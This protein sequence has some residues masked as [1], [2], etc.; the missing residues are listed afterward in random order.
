MAKV[1]PDPD[2]KAPRPDIRVV[3]GRPGIIKK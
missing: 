2:K 3:V 1:K